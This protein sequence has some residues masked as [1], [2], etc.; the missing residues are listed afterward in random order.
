MATHHPRWTEPDPRGVYPYAFECDRDQAE[1]W[2]G[3]DG[4]PGVVTAPGGVACTLDAAPDVAAMLGV[5]FVPPPTPR[6]SDASRAKLEALGQWPHQITGAHRIATHAQ[7]ILA[8]DPRGGKTGTAIGAVLIRGWSRVLIVCVIPAAR[9]VWAEQ[10]K[11]FAREPALMLYGRA[12]DRG[13]WYGE[14]K[15]LREAELDVA[16]RTA[17]W[18]IVNPEILAGHVT[19]NRR[20]VVGIVDHLPGWADRLAALRWDICYVDE[21]HRASGWRT[22]SE[23]SKRLAIRRTCERI[24]RVWALTATP[25][26]GGMIR[27]LWGVVDITSG[28]TW[29]GPEP[30]RFLKRW[31]NA[32]SVEKQIGRDRVIRVWDD[33]GRSNLTELRQRINRYVL[34]RT[35]KEFAPHMPP[36]IREIVWVESDDDSAANRVAEVLAASKGQSLPGLK[37]KSSQLMAADLKEVLPRCAD[38]ATE[39]LEAGEKII[40][41]VARHQSLRA[42]MATF[43]KHRGTKRFPVFALHGEIAQEA[44]FEIAQAFVNA[45][46]AA[47][48][49]ALIDAVPGAISLAGATVEHWL[50]VHHD[51]NDCVQAEDRPYERDTRGLLIKYWAICGSISQHRLEILLPKIETLAMLKQENDIEGLTALVK[52]RP[53]E[54]ETLVDVWARLEADIIA[55]GGEFK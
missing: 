22:D 6:L 29:G 37:S 2:A 26:R 35:R 12:A 33:T 21:A 54:A 39:Q 9:P 34:R 44:R 11:R 46:G 25:I 23:A 31:C 45:P 49:F 43:S 36:K 53:K 19:A 15:Y 4:I 40:V 14:R 20:G 18:V 28:S 13:R 16:L 42:A 38:D 17:R 5:E 55:G 32:H 48:M 51:P 8:D 41:F 27:M 10:I 47:V 24:P 50:E 52:T 7:G 30:W 3:R 1:R